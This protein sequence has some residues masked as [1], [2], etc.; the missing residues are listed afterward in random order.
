MTRYFLSKILALIICWAGLFSLNA[1]L[2]AQSPP[3]G[4][5]GGLAGDIINVVHAGGTKV[6]ITYEL[7]QDIPTGSI[8][9]CVHVVRV[10]GPPLTGG[11]YEGKYAEEQDGF[12]ID[13]NKRAGPVNPGDPPPQYTIRVDLRYP[14]GDY[15][16][17]FEVGDGTTFSNFFTNFRFDY[18]FDPPV[19]WAQDG[20]VVGGDGVAEVGATPL[21]TTCR[22][23]LY[24]VAGV[25]EN[26]GNT[27]DTAFSDPSRYQQNRETFSLGIVPNEADAG[28]VPFSWFACAENMVYQSNLGLGFFTIF[29]SSA[30]GF[31]VDWQPAMNP[32]KAMLRFVDVPTGRVFTFEDIIPSQDEVEAGLTEGALDGKLYDEVGAIKEARLLDD[33]NNLV[34]AI[35]DATKLEIERQSG[36]IMTFERFDFDFAGDDDQDEEYDAEYRLVKWVN[37]DQ[38]GYEITYHNDNTFEIDTITDRFSRVIKYQYG[39][40]VGGREAITSIILPNGTTASVSYNGVHISQVSVGTLWNWTNNVVVDH[41]DRTLDFEI[42]SPT[43]CQ[44]KYRY[45]LDVRELRT[46]IV[47]QPA[48]SI[49]GIFS[50]DESERLLE[51][52]PDATEEDRDSMLV[53]NHSI[54]VVEQ[55]VSISFVAPV[56]GT[57]LEYEENSFEPTGGIGQGGG[58]SINGT[59]KQFTL[60]LPTDRRTRQ[61][62]WIDCDY[63]LD[64]F[65]TKRTLEEDIPAETVFESW[66]YND[67]KKI[68]RYR[69]R[70]GRVTKY[71]HDACGNVEQRIVGMFN[72]DPDD[73]PA[74]DQSDPN[75][76]ATYLADYHDSGVLKGQLVFTQDPLGNRTDFS[77]YGDGTIQ[78]VTAPADESGGERNW[79]TYTYDAHVRL[80][81]ITEPYDYGTT[82]GTRD[83]KVY[84]YDA[85][86]RVIEI[87]Y[88]DG[89]T[90]KFEYGDG[91]NAPQ[92]Q[93]YRYKDRRGIFT[94]F[95]YDNLCRVTEKIV[96]VAKIEAGS[97]VACNDP[98]EQVKT[99][100]T[101]LSGTSLPETINV[102]GS[103]THYEY[104]AVNRVVETRVTPDANSTPLVSKTVYE[105]S[106]RFYDE[107]PYGRRTYNSYYLPTRYNQRTV[108]EA[109][110]NTSIR[111]VVTVNI[112]TSP[113]LNRVNPDRNAPYVIV[114]HDTDVEGQVTDVTDRREI[115]SSHEYDWRGRNFRNKYALGLNEEIQSETVY[116]KANNILEKRKPR[117]FSSSAV[118]PQGSGKSFEK[119]Q[120][121]G[122]NLVC[123]MTDAPISSELSETSIKYYLDKNLKWHTD[124]RP[125]SS[126]E[127][128]GGILYCP[129]IKTGRFMGRGRETDLVNLSTPPGVFENTDHGGNRTHLAPGVD[130]I[131][132]NADANGTTDLV[133]NETEQEQTIRLDNLQRMSGATVWNINCPAIDPEKPE[134]ANIGSADGFTRQ[135]LYDEDLADGVGL[136]SATGITPEFGGPTVNLTD[137]LTKLAEPIAQGGADI[138]FDNDADGR[139]VVR[140]NHEL[141]LSVTIYDCL[142]RPVMNAVLDRDDG[143]SLIS[144]SC[145]QYDNI[146]NVPGFGECVETVSI[147]ADGNTDR[148][149]VDRLGRT[150]QTLDALSKITAYEYDANTNVLSV[151]DP[152]GV[153][154]R[155]NT[156]DGL[157]RLT[158][159]IDTWGD[160]TQATY[161]ANGNTKTVT[162]ARSHITTYVYDA[163]DRVSEVMD[164]L[165][166]ITKY[167]YDQNN[168][169][170]SIEDAD[171]EN[172]V[173]NIT[174]Y[175]YD[176]RN[177]LRKIIYPDHVDGTSPGD[178]GYGI[179]EIS[180]YD[181]S[182]R[183]VKR[184]D[185]A[186]DLVKF[187]YDIANRTKQREYFAHGDHNTVV[188]TDSFD[189]DGVNRIKSATSG[190]YTNTCEFDYD[191]AGRKWKE[192]LLA[193][194]KTY[195]IINEY[196]TNSRL[197]KLTYP[198]GTICERN[199]TPRWSL[200]ETRYKGA[201]IETRTYDDAARLKTCVTGNGK[202][203]TYTY[204]E[205]GADRDNMIS[206][207]DISGITSF[208][209]TY[210]AN[211]NKT[212]ENITGTMLPW[213][214]SSSGY[215]KENRIT[216]WNRADGSRNLAW[217]RSMVGD[218]TNYS[219]N[220]TS[221]NRTYNDAHELTHID[222]VQKFEYDA[223]GNMV[224]DDQGRRHIYD[225]DNKL[226][227]I[228]EDDN[229]TNDYQQKYDALGRRIAYK[230]TGNS[231]MYY[232]CAGSQLIAEYNQA[233]G[234]TNPRRKYIYGSYIDEPIALDRRTSSNWNLFYYHRNAQMSIAAVTHH[235]GSIRERYAYDAY[236]NTTILAANGTTVRSS[237]NMNNPFMYTGRFYHSDFE[238][239]YFRARFYYPAQGQFL[240]RD[241]KGYVDGA[242]LY[243]GYFSP[244]GM[245]PTGTENDVEFGTI[246]DQKMRLPADSRGNW[247]EGERGNGTFRY[248]DNAENRS[249]NIVGLEVKFENGHIAV[250]GFPDQYYYKGNAKSATVDISTVG[251]TVTGSDDIAARDAMRKLL[252][253]NSW[254]KPDGYTWHHAGGEGSTKLELVETDFHK[255]VAHKGPAAPHRAATRANRIRARGLAV[256]D[257]YMTIR[258]AAEYAG[259]GGLKYQESNFK[260]YYYTERDSVFTVHKPVV[261]LFG[262]KPWKKYVAG[263][264]AGQTQSISWAQAEQF[265]LRAERK[266]GKFIRG[267]LFRKPRFKPG[268]HRHSIPITDRFG[269]TIGHIDEDGPTMYYNSG[270]EPWN[271]S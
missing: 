155:A 214:F 64:G 211:K 96:G 262:A 123:Q 40:V 115:D 23:D 67:D 47:A 139:A 84:T 2:V 235:D 156:F 94:R 127:G 143:Q 188:D 158:S 114:E 241:P 150:I 118:D 175:E 215:D 31:M 228:D 224:K 171:Q 238:K 130:N 208:A 120:Y 246:P 174:R 88:A 223:K 121:N 206:T 186:G 76:T 30:H 82:S 173:G 151:L 26:I 264:K 226:R 195:E 225:F 78:K 54:M 217:V 20:F 222:G 167:A 184:I 95:Q 162:D 53:G 200:F 152:E 57:V 126:I 110:S 199:Y 266:W 1:T 25:L 193:N 181:S 212:A 107:D 92:G 14:Y 149:H 248:E 22:N 207:I 185:Q 137:C 201:L 153:G 63:D 190:R 216:V 12:E 218:W 3:P 271:M 268:T 183:M 42:N 58:G 100:Y 172:G 117:Y 124:P 15:F 254:T 125:D 119:F 83:A 163:R 255:R 5:G 32:P 85:L 38:Q 232:I 240:N 10:W 213:G 36:E 68:E 46:H 108:T 244:N 236:G 242:S 16:V 258:D 27:G 142:N 131:V 252:N 189:Y 134:I 91:A 49:I 257:V 204:R 161:D 51:I 263:P 169:I 227:Y 112:K 260:L 265:K 196:D 74:A 132:T 104:D 102:N 45:S 233:A 259:V 103:I 48:N 141:E 75:I 87:T 55:G 19:I 203:A 28:T 33:N 177:L 231:W 37:L 97:E 41:D 62:T 168:N 166:G 170:I 21:P 253:D 106:L 113:T 93:I 7:Y 122:R 140:I 72:D 194:N 178:A 229:G 56:G 111:S 138:T 81:K 209:Y 176:E 187:T 133:D 256:L 105:N 128:Q 4:G 35:K 65:L 198:D 182:R 17:V 34:T 147:D 220:G 146:V 70:L 44:R 73:D 18:D 237:S 219:V 145:M 261:G 71:V 86:N 157:N 60:G 24:P 116:D 66:A 90:E 191:K 230:K 135:S 50:Q 136:D 165:G 98:N 79:N 239:Y 267:T 80:E 77:Y 192:R 179:I 245:D 13:Q 9:P 247:I 6:D 61:G 101:Y 197:I 221:E 164:R 8:A 243:A 148:V 202:T 180:E 234:L 270:F 39:Q 205:N 249:R 69:D 159:S 43:V 29:D 154:I 109:T 59:L 99:E 250:G 52:I 89:S 129:H 160:E 210:D 144:W 11:R 269:R 251:A